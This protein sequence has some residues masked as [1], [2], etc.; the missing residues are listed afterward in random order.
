MSS[1]YNYNPNPPRAWSRVQNRCTYFE[2][3]NP[4]DQ[5]Y[6][7]LTGQSVSQAEANYEEKLYYKGNILQYKA[8]S[9][10]LT[11]KQR[12]SQL[13]KGFGPNR[14]K[15]FAT[16]TQTY[17]NPNTTGLLRVNYSTFPFPNQ[18]VGKPNNISGPF[19]YDVQSPFDCSNNSV[20][21]GGN[22]VCGTYA[23]PC[24]GEIIQNNLSSATICNPSYCSD[25]PGRPIELCWNNK[26]QT[27]FPRQ[28]Y[29]MN[30]SGNKWPQGY[31]GFVSAVRPGP[32]YLM[33]DSYTSTTATLSWTNP[34]E[35]CAQITSYNIYK[36]NIL[37]ESVPYT[38]NMQ[39]ITISGL[40]DINNFYI[41]SLI[42]NI[43]ENSTIIESNPSNFV[44]SYN[45]PF[46]TTGSPTINYLNN[47]YTLTFNTTGSITFD[48]N[49]YVDMLA[50]GGG[51]GGGGS[52]A[53]N[54]YRGGGGG[55]GGG[56]I[57]VL[58]NAYIEPAT[59][60]IIVGSGG[61]GGKK[62]ITDDNEYG[63]GVL[64]GAS[65]GDTKISKNNDA[66][67][68][69]TATGGTGGKTYY[70]NSL[71]GISGIS[72]K[73]T[74]YTN[75]VFY[76]YNTA[77]GGNG[78]KNMNS[79]YSNGTAN[80]SST[81]KPD[82]LKNIAF[83]SGGDGGSQFNNSNGNNGN[84]YGSGGGGGA[85]SLDNV[86]SYTGGKGGDGIVIIKFKYP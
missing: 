29:F 78:Y 64:P 52:N 45:I 19:Q 13:A 73:S 84:T 58:L 41:T 22:L 18:L 82:I 49:F 48:Y 46:T 25:V 5:I 33:L 37:I 67:N 34:N 39:P 31:K 60:S 77:N 55:G 53:Q 62:G 57:G 10:S 81:I 3:G 59:Y 70:Q 72:E 47:Y 66:S 36:N 15:V 8:N 83:N 42:I 54:N 44:T 86:K 14:T 30:N 51:G 61:S 56:G 71:G 20:Q 11:K 24:T 21:D 28:R 85:Y 38:S 69:L 1:G 7:P 2:E 63:E 32:P 26:L 16:Q 35:K 12:Y 74:S 76:N 23:N 4:Y 80:I 17:T 50:I 40:M 68:Y 6:I 65:G 79:V 43:E 9:S 75:N 27:F